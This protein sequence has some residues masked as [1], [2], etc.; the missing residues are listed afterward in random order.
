MVEPG[1][2]KPRGRIQ[3][4]RSGIAGLYI[5]C[6]VRTV[7]VYHKSGWAIHERGVGDKDLVVMFRKTK[8]ADPT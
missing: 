5:D 2:Q 3:P 1:S 4:T 7:R 8:A 6:H